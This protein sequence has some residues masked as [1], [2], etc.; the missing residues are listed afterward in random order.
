MVVALNKFST[1]MIAIIILLELN[2][3]SWMDAYVVERKAPEAVATSLLSAFPGE[4]NAAKASNVLLTASVAA[5]LVSKEIYLIDGEFF[6]MLCIFGAYYVWFSGGKDMAAAYFADK[7][8][9]FGL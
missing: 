8:K 5:F 1:G 3:F 9:V 7:Q 6:E 4:S 2:L